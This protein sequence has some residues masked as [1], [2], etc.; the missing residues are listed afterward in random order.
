VGTPTQTL[1]FGAPTNSGQLFKSRYEAWEAGII[2]YKGADAFDN[3]QKVIDRT[4]AE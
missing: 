4:L 3:I 1:Q 2:D